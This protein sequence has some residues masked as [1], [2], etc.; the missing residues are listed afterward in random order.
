LGQTALL[1]SAAKT[2]HRK[3]RNERKGEEQMGP[4]ADFQTI[5]EIGVPGGPGRTRTYNQQ[6]M[7][8]LL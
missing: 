8:L 3:V 6:I 7:S 1:V 4:E 2:I 5:E